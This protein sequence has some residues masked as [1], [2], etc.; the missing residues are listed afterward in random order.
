M[1]KITLARRWGVSWCN[2]A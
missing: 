2:S 1:K